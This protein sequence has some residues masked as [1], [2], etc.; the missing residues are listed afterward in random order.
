M[1]TVAAALR[2]ASDL[3]DY[4]YAGGGLVLVIGNEGNG[5]LQSTIGA[6]SAVVKIP[7]CSM[8]SLNAAAAAA[9]PGGI[10]PSPCEYFMRS[11]LFTTLRNS[12]IMVLC[13]FM[14]TYGMRDTLYD[15]H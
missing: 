6:C 5:L 14:R 3:R 8:E 7:I 4:Q 15:Y 13:N 12:L 2:G 11:A 1:E 10:N 9:H